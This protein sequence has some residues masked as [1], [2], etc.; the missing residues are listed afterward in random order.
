MSLVAWRRPPGTVYRFVLLTAGS[1]SRRQGPTPYQTQA[2]AS[3]LSRVQPLLPARWNHI[4]H[5]VAHRAKQLIGGIPTRLRPASSTESKP[6][7]CHSKSG[8]RPVRIGKKAEPWSRGHIGTPED[9]LN[10]WEPLATAS[11]SLEGAGDAFQQAKTPSLDP[12][13]QACHQ[14]LA[15]KS[16]GNNLT[17]SW[18]LLSM[19]ISKSPFE[20]EHL[21]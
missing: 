16:L 21:P 19:K 20:L 11:H 8:F 6:N 2:W 17:C 4:I 1:P 13:H 18:P 12:S 9:R 5:R 10:H 3:V 7:D 15:P 14:R